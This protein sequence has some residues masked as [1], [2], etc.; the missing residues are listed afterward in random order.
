M[1]SGKFTWYDLALFLGMGVTVW[2]VV[3]QDHILARAKKDLERLSRKHPPTDD[4]GHQ[5][6]PS[7]PDEILV[8]DSWWEPSVT[9]IAI[10]RAAGFGAWLGYFKQTATDDIYSGWS[11]ATFKLVQ[12]GGLKTGAYCSQHDDPTWV[13]TRAAAL[14]IIA[15]LDDESG[16][17]PDNSGTDAWLTTAGAH[18]YGGSGVQAT[19]RTHGH[20]GY[21]FSEYPT[22]GNPSGLNWPNGF[23]I[24][25]PPRPLGWQYSDKGSIAG[26]TVDLSIFDPA[27]FGQPI[28]VEE[29]DDVKPAFWDST[30]AP[31]QSNQNWAWVDTQGNLKHAWSGGGIETLASDLIPSSQVGM[32]II[33]NDPGNPAGGGYIELTALTMDGRLQ[34]FWG[35]TAAPWGME[36][37]GTAE[38]LVATGGGLTVGQAAELSNA[39]AALGRIEAALKGA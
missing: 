25:E 3:V 20:V 34:H 7:P 31:W 1:I 14:G 18:L 26:L 16:I 32:F 15:I 21:V 22:A 39:V 27:I 8:A 28:I 35:G 33:Y 38:P 13:R 5:P 23:A 10:A 37:L 6:V 19:H 4:H 36:L 29:D 12:A 2:R 9:Q 17:D 24:P 11:D 30:S